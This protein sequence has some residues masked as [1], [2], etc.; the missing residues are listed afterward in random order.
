M[1][2]MAF[3]LFL[4]PRSLLFSAQPSKT[5]ISSS[6]FLNS[7]I[8]MKIARSVVVSVS[9]RSAQAEPEASDYLLS[10]AFWKSYRYLNKST[11][12]G[13]SAG[14][15]I[16]SSND[17]GVFVTTTDLKKIKYRAP[18]PRNWLPGF[19]SATAT[20]FALSI[21]SSFSLIEWIFRN[22]LIWCAFFQFYGFFILISIVRPF[23]QQFSI[24][25]FFS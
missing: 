22:S 14:N 12:N 17:C 10:R 25:I 20:V 11:E 16:T 3:N 19:E 18:L 13:S 8:S 5:L 9:F 4:S 23:F 1:P 7:R 15:I 2:F 21:P 6:S 24:N